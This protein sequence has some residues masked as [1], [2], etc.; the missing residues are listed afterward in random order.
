M[1]S[2]AEIQNTILLFTP[3]PWAA[4]SMETAVLLQGT[5]CLIFLSVSSCTEIQGFLVMSM[6]TSL[7]LIQEAVQ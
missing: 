1:N 5:Q 2:Y 4:V 7:V 3:S 6:L